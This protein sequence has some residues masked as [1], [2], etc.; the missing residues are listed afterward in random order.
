MEATGKPNVGLVID[1]WHFWASRGAEPEDIARLDAD[2]IYG[3]HVSDGYRPDEGAP[4]PDETE[5]RGVLPGEGDI[6]IAEWTDAVKATGFDG[7]V[8]GEF[9]NPFLWERDHV[10]VATAMREAMERYW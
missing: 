7:F 2:L 8:S 10:E 5:L 9:L 1:Y 3:V 6:P 4:W